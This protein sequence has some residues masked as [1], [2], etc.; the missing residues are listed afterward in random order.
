MT[1]VP[2]AEIPYVWFSGL[3]QGVRGLERVQDV[4]EVYYYHSEICA[5]ARYGDGGFCFHMRKTRASLRLRYRICLDH[6][7]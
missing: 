2:P 1:R 4:G 3:K 6:H 7:V 5:I